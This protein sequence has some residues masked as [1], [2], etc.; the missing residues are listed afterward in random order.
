MRNGGGFRPLA[1]LLLIGFI[2]L[3]ALGAYGAGF[4]AGNG[5]AFT[6]ANPP[7]WAYYGPGF[8]F[9]V[10]HLVG[11]LVTILIFIIIVRLILAVIFGGHRHR[12][13]GPRG[14]WQGGDPAQF[15][16]SGP[17]GGWHR[18][19]WHEVGQSYFDEFHNRA[20][21]N[22]PPAG[23][24]AAAGPVTGGPATDPAVGPPGADRQR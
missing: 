16:P 14:Y 3:I 18:G 24:P 11:F 19:P 13:W 17:Y 20:H 21:G 9:G 10:G 15:G 8:G 23:G 7:S 4:A 2:G 12:H 6:P 5:P 1:A 22:V